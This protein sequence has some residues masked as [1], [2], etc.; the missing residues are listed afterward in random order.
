[1]ADDILHGPSDSL[2]GG[3]GVSK[4]EVE[5]I[6]TT[7]AS[8]KASKAEVEPKATKVEVEAK[9][10]DL[11]ADAGGFLAQNFDPYA[12]SNSAVAGTKERTYFVKV[13]LPRTVT[14]SKVV[15]FVG[16]TAGGTLSNCAAG[17]YKSD[18]TRLGETASQN[19]NWESL[20]EK[21]MALGSSVEVIGG[22]GKFV[23]VAFVQNGTTMPSFVRS[24]N[25]GGVAGT[26][27]IGTTAS[28]L[29]VGYVAGTSLP[30]PVTPSSM[31]IAS[32][33]ASFWAAVM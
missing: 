11:G 5:E 16:T 9:N 29:R 24:A 6:A 8:T 23:W 1:M 19:T 17:L 33:L 13:V 22:E 18:G 31:L 25:A 3:E 27:N 30:S 4:A 14:I 7:A 21:Q 20:G 2:G 12:S 26:L 15:L 32:G 28:T 10:R